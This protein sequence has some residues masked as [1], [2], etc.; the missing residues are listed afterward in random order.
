[1][2]VSYRFPDGG[3]LLHHYLKEKNKH[4]NEEHYVSYL[5]ERKIEVNAVDKKGISAL[6]YALENGYFFSYL[7]IYKKRKYFKMNLIEQKS[8]YL[9]HVFS[10]PYATR[11][12]N[13]FN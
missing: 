5:L 11:N 1:L 2:N 8:L 13:F 9:P 3:T 4:N 7:A 10:E 6:F 12:S